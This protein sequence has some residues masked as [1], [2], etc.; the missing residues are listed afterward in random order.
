MPINDEYFH[1]SASCSQT[2]IINRASAVAK[3]RQKRRQEGSVKY[4]WK[5]LLHRIKN[6]A[7]S[8]VDIYTP[9]PSSGCWG[10]R[11]LLPPERNEIAS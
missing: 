8:V 9:R 6:D 11:E 2:L 10:I 4:V 1:K 5:N 3:Q 7:I